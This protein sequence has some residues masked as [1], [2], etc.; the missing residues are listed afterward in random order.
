MAG[1]RLKVA[2]FSVSCR[3][4]ASVTNK[5]LGKKGR[6]DSGSKAVAPFS[7]ATKHKT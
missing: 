5:V 1:K 4:S 2:G 6:R 3:W 7:S